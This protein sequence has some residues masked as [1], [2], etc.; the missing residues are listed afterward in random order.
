MMIMM[1]KYIN[2]WF[3]NIWLSTIKSKESLARSISNAKKNKMILIFIKISLK[4]YKINRIMYIN[5]L[6]VSS[7]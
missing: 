2:T 4:W 6:Y 5:L 3:E 1:N 7:N